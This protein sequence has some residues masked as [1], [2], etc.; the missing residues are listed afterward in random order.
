M[1]LPTDLREEAEATGLRLAAC[2]R[3]AIE[4]VVGAE[5]TSHDLSFALNLD[6]VIA[7]R[8]VKMIRPNMT[9]AEAL[10]KAPSAS[11]LRLFADRCAQAGALSPLDLGALRDAIRRFE[12]LIRRAGPSKGALTTMLR[13]GAATSQAS[14][15]VRPIMQIRADGAI[16][17]LDDAY[18]EPWGVW[19]ELNL[20]ASD[21]DFDVLLAAEASRIACWSG[22]PGK[23][24]FERS[25]ES[26]S[27][28]AMERLCD[29]CTELAPR[30]RDAGKTLLLRPHARHVLCDAARCASFIRDR[31]RPNNWPIGLAL[32]PAALIEQ[33]MQ[34]DIEDHI[35]RILESLGG[36]CAC[37]MLP[38]S[39]D[40]AERAQV[41][42]LMPA[43]IPFITTG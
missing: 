14:V 3:H 23:G 9:G 4:T 41:E 25:P 43:P 15:A 33:D 8:I 37:V 16:R 17:S 2:V 40:D 1:A 28:G 39:L 5:P 30:L 42:A 12:G 6:G 24:M 11:N 19:R 13:E 32:D 36:L 18:A 21:A 20:L 22:H 26:W 7:K 29:M 10:T 31:A 27:A 35:T 34:G 38:A